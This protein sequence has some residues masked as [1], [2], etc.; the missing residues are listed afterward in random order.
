[1][2]VQAHVKF[3]P[4]VLA[5][6][7]EL[8]LGA[9]SQR[10]SLGQAQ[11]N[12]DVATLLQPMKG[13][14]SGPYYMPPMV[15]TNDDSLVILAR[16]LSHLRLSGL[17]IIIEPTWRGTAATIL[18]ATLL[19]SSLDPDG[20]VLAIPADF[21]LPDSVALTSELVR[22]AK[23][24]ETKKIVALDCG[25]HPTNG[26]GGFSEAPDPVEP[27]L[28][29]GSLVV[30]NG[31]E[32]SVN[33]VARGRYPK[34][35]RIFLFQASAMIAAFQA[36]A[37]EEIPLISKAVEAVRLKSGIRRLDPALWNALPVGSIDRILDECSNTVTRPL[38]CR[39]TCRCGSKSASPDGLT[40]IGAPV[41]AADGHRSVMLRNQAAMI[42]QRSLDFQQGEY[43]RC[44]RSWGWDE[45]L[46][47]EKRFQ[48]KR[49]MVEPGASISVRTHVHRV[50]HWVVVFGTARVTIDGKRSLISESQSVFVPVG[51]AQGIENPGRVPLILIIVQTGAYLED[52]GVISD[53][54]ACVS[55][56]QNQMIPD[57][58]FHEIPFPTVQEDV[59]SAARRES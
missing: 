4:V 39:Q 55:P 34:S 30:K 23:L 53:E 7:S 17:D 38:A 26:S 51:A 40:A 27:S 1:M 14:F 24:A 35:T 59:N 48:V 37:K 33:K 36:Q 47:R 5:G 50:E 28:A 44:H 21:M 57:R 13:R 31:I 22:L 15:M 29:W 32:H 52:D 25:A 46:A 8:L 41:A 3:Y 43:I 11:V 6:G 20:L 42:G 18:A 45:L 19:V 16:H 12:R 54:E 2:A 58:I 10:T 56:V 9:Q 49:I